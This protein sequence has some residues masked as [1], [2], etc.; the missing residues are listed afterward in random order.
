MFRR[1]PAEAQRAAEQEIAI[2]EEYLLPLL[3]S[4]GQF[5]LGWALAAQSAL[6]EG[7]ELIADRVGRDQCDRR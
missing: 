5:Q 1:E 2:C 3:L 6:D 7:I 4:Q